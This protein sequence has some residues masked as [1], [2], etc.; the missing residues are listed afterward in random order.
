MP[1]LEGDDDETIRRNIAELIDA[2]HPADQAVAIAHEFARRHARAD[3][4]F[5]DVP[6]AVETP[7][8]SA[9]HWEQSDGRAGRTV[10]MGCHYGYFPGTV[11]EDGEGVDVFLGPRPDAPEVYVVH[12]MAAPDFD[13]YD[14]DK[15]MAGF[16]SADD[17]RR[18]F[19]DHYDD[20][21]FLGSMSSFP[22][23]ELAERLRRPGGLRA[24]S[25]EPLRLWMTRRYGVDLSGASSADVVQRASRIVGR[26]QALALCRLDEWDESQHPRGE[27]GRFGEGGEHAATAERHA[28]TA[29][30]AASGTTPSA[31]ASARRAA[32]HAALARVAAQSFD[33]EGA[34]H[35]AR[36]AERHSLAAQLKATAHQQSGGPAPTPKAPVELTS[37]ERTILRAA[38]DQRGKPEAVARELKTLAE[39]PAARDLIQKLGLKSA[40]DL[41]QYASDLPRDQLPQEA[42][43]KINS[44]TRSTPLDATEQHVMSQALTDLSKPDNQR[45]V[46]DLLNQS[47][48]HYGFSP[49]PRKASDDQIRVTRQFDGV[50]RQVVPSATYNPV[51][52]RIDILPRVAQSSAEAL[53]KLASGERPLSFEMKDY[54][55]L[56]HETLHGHGPQSSFTGG[57]AVVE[58]ITT[59]VSARRVARDVFGDHARSAGDAF[60][61]PR[62]Q[63]S[64]GAYSKWIFNAT[65]AIA[66][67]LTRSD[68]PMREAYSMLERACLD[69]KRTGGVGDRLETLLS[70]I[71][72]DGLSDD[73]HQRVVDGL[74]RSI[75]E[76]R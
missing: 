75:G 9:R 64:P 20:P 70:K 37:H 25:A 7:E 45:V 43:S 59:E 33:V 73:E 8:G 53:R 63:G 12:Q 18:A 61:M 36:E 13:H 3:A 4:A 27:D 49:N 71:P 24:D 56:V 11:G 16:A 57:N 6:V 46:R 32:E 28:A 31:R 5:A 21:R 54:R 65:D 10:M 69:Y 50:K 76:Q 62:H 39:L 1:L 17:A 40:D 66:S 55:T 35:H 68:S 26:R 74:R 34:A 44:S 19:L 30:A 67:A 38:R 52:G 58:E 72:R 41:R 47:I 15:V 2:G 14:E 22:T 60:D 48:A 42:S 51:N 23:G 29:R